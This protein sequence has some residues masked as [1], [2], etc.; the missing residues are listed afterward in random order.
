MNRVQS[1]AFTVQ[2]CCERIWNKYRAS[3]FTASNGN[4]L[5]ERLRLQN[6]N[7]IVALPE[8]KARVTLSDFLASGG[9]STSN[10]SIVP[11]IPPSN[12]YKHVLTPAQMRLTLDAAIATFHLHVES[13]IAALC[14]QGFYTIGPCGEE[15][16]ASIGWALD[17]YSDAVALHYRHLSVSILRQLRL[18]RN[19]EDVI[20][21]RARGHV[22]S[23]LDPVTG[24]VRPA[25]V[26]KTLSLLQYLITNLTLMR[27]FPS[28]FH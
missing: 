17:P 1:K 27:M 7:E 4:G 28:I 15:M 19:L 3:S 16:L 22:V 20:L 8:F 24:G 14:G 23:M 11:I 25:I 9:A 2:R 12:G 10:N 26:F 6:E 13:R 21:D 18:G 5:L